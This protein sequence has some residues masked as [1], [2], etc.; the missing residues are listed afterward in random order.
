[1][2]R[3][4]ASLLRTFLSHRTYNLSWTT[5]VARKYATEATPSHSHSGRVNA[6]LADTATL[7]KTYKP[8]TPGLRHLRR[9]RNAHLYEGRPVRELTVARRKK[10][11]R[12][13]QG[14]ITV[15]H[16][17]G[18]HKQRIR[19]I[20]FVRDIP[21]IHDV[22]RIEF[23]PG[24]SAHIALVQSRDTN[25]GQQKFSYILAPEGLRAGDTVRSFRMGIPDDIAPEYASPEEQSSNS[26]KTESTAPSNSVSTDISLAMGLLRSLTVK[27]G[28]VLPL[29]FIPPGTHIHNI[30]LKPEGRGILVRSAGSF[31]TVVAHAHGERYVQVRLQSGEIR[32]VLQD[33]CATIG[34]VSNPLWKD[35]SLGKAGRSRWLGHRPKVRGVAMNAYAFPTF[36]SS[37]RL[38]DCV[39]SQGRSPSRRWTW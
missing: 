8:V 9:P 16:I 15:R 10:G 32:K 19:I 25:A 29:K 33:C 36:A 30:S 22:V 34:A 13:N 37:P 7:Y 28:N 38:A 27:V 18:G 6:S 12:N 4:R 5:T 26:E 20:D 31:A 14:R 23:D 17:G 2:F 24:R 35:R 1:M 11:G 21:G 39:K 3:C